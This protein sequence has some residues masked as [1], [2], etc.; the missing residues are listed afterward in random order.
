MKSILFKVTCDEGEL[1]TLFYK[2][3]LAQ[4]PSNMGSSL[5]LFRL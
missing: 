3:R 4:L 1:L 5:R 2:I